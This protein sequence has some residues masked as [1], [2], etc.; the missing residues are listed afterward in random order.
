MVC[1]NYHIVPRPPFQG[2]H[3]AS[4]FYPSLACQYIPCPNLLTIFCLTLLF[5][6]HL[7]IKWLSTLCIVNS[8]RFLTRLHCTCVSQIKTQEFTSFFHILIKVIIPRHHFDRS[9]SGDETPYLVVLDTTVN[10]NNFKLA[11]WIINFGFL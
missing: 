3:P 5:I 1:L 8:L 11:V 2:V 9:P 4:G 7:N 10:S 6:V